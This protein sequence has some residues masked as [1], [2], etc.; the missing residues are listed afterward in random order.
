MSGGQVQDMRV[1]GAGGEGMMRH[2]RG[3]WAWDIVMCH[4]SADSHDNKGIGS[5]K[6]QVRHAS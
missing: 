6:V 3:M 5:R 2:M 4:Q 1:Q